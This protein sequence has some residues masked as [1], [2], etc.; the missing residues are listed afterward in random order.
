MHNITVKSNSF[1]SLS[2]KSVINSVL[3]LLFIISTSTQASE[4][5]CTV[6]KYIFG[7]QKNDL[8]KT[9]TFDKSGEQFR[10]NTKDKTFGSYI[11]AKGEWH[12][13]NL[14][15]KSFSG[16]IHFHGYLTYGVDINRELE[17]GSYISLILTENEKYFLRTF[18]E[19]SNEKG[20]LV[21]TL[22]NGTCVKL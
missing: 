1:S 5:I 6:D 13:V 11:E 4:L 2:P 3:I 15:S 16:N 22:E 14:E 7:K 18:T 21:G 12:W 8:L 9:E 20:G 17:V 10:I 19:F